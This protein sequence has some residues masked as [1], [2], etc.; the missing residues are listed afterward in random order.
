MFCPALLPC[1]KHCLDSA[2]ASFPPYGPSSHPHPPCS[3]AFPMEAFREMQPPSL[4]SSAPQAQPFVWG[5]SV[6]PWL[7]LIR[8]VTS[9]LA[10]QGTRGRQTGAARD[11]LHPQFS[12]DRI[13]Q[14]QD[15]IFEDEHWPFHSQD[16][17]AQAG[18]GGMGHIERTN[19]TLFLLLHPE[20]RGKGGISISAKLGQVLQHWLADLTVEKQREIQKMWENHSTM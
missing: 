18:C 3:E 10:I 20:G 15:P 1:T 4:P 14:H 5:H 16:W 8:R 13:W 12:P 9:V 17:P 6:S 2:P 7:V 19:S 11:S